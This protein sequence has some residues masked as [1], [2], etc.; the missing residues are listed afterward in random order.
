MHFFLH[1]ALLSFWRFAISL[2]QHRNNL[3]A[4][5]LSIW[6]DSQISHIHDLTLICYSC[7]QRIP[8][9]DFATN[10]IP[11]LICQFH[12]PIAVMIHLM[13]Y[14][15]PSK[16]Y[17]FKIWNLNVPFPPFPTTWIQHPAD[18]LVR[19]KFWFSYPIQCRVRERSHIMSAVEGGGGVLKSDICWHK[20]FFWGEARQLLSANS[21]LKIM[22]FWIVMKLQIRT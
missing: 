8:K 6:H 22:F 3:V 4:L 15:T 21:K 16:M 17:C 1:W 9:F 19:V 11:N 7:L 18:P 2:S 14:F 10:A 13:M 20:F 12:Y 5:I